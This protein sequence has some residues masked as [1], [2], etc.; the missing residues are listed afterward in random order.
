MNINVSQLR[1]IIQ[2][3]II[4]EL[5]EPTLQ[6]R[7]DALRKQWQIDFKLNPVEV[8]SALEDLMEKL[9]K[10][11]IKFKMGRTSRNDAARLRGAIQVLNEY[12]VEGSEPYE[13]LLSDVAV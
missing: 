1:R 8:V 2:E 11:S 3:E 4:K 10:S 9:E 13:N 12:L 7:V 5:G 6:D